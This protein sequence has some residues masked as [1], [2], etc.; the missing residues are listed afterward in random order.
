MVILVLCCKDLVLNTDMMLFIPF[1]SFRVLIHPIRTRN[2]LLHLPKPQTKTEA[3]ISITRIVPVP[4][5]RTE[6]FHEPLS[7]VAIGL[8]I[9]QRKEGRGNICEC[10]WVKKLK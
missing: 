4:E 8:W 5:T 3:H 6:S 9:E 7:S 1:H 10:S 2:T